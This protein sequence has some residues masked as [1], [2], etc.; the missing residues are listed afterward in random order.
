[1]V[2]LT[3]TYVFS[4]R[5]PR[6][7]ATQSLS[8][9]RSQCSLSTLSRNLHKATVEKHLSM[10]IGSL[11]LSMGRLLMPSRF[12]RSTG[13]SCSRDPAKHHL[14]M[15]WQLFPTSRQKKAW[16]SFSGGILSPTKR[17]SSQIG[18]VPPFVC[19]MAC[20][21]KDDPPSRLEPIRRQVLRPSN[22]IYRE[23]ALGIFLIGGWGDTSC[24]RSFSNTA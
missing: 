18:D 11:G 7:E 3:K 8:Y 21:T 19:R 16:S 2:L 24:R 9:S 17:K 6:R 5:F 22:R 10:S 1:L 15:V 12:T 14:R 4:T 13:N 23:I 20:D